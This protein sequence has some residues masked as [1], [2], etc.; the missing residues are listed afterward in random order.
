MSGGSP[1]G[2]QRRSRGGCGLQKSAQEIF[3]HFDGNIQSLAFWGVLE[4]LVGD[5]P[6]LARPGIHAKVV[7]MSA[8]DLAK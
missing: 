2:V 7:I 5:Y 4:M 6:M 8:L 1:E 3:S